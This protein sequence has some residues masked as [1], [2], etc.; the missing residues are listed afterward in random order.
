MEAM[1]RFLGPDL[2]IPIDA[3][4]GGGVRCSAYF[5]ITMDECITA[6][7]CA[8]G[9]SRCLFRT[10]KLPEV[11]CASICSFPGGVLMT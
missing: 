2:K 10:G 7:T 1:A 3:A 8:N 6:M 11:S 5:T 9:A 4:N